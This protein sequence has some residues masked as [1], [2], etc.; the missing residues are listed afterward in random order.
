[1]SPN[2]PVCRADRR[3]LMQKDACVLSMFLCQFTVEKQT[4]IMM[5]EVLSLTTAAESESVMECAANILVMLQP[6]NIKSTD[7]LKHQ[8]WQIKKE[9]CIL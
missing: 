9:L 4:F 3:A 8:K 2:G 7:Y 1:M 6:S 5:D